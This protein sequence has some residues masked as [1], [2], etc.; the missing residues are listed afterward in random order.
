M[1]AAHHKLTERQQ[2]TV[3]TAQAKLMTSQVDWFLKFVS[4]TLRAKQVIRD[5]DVRHACCA[6]LVKLG[7]RE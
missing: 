5:T 2:L 4:D 3:A 7:H 1:I 6:G